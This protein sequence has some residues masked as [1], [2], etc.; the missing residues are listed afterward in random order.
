MSSITAAEKN[1]TMS[2]TDT[3]SDS[4]M[5]TLVA[6]EKRVEERVGKAGR[7]AWRFFHELPGHGALLGGAVG[8][9]GVVFIGFAESW[10]DSDA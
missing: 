3:D 4:G 2:M 8:L 1:N 9:A 5:N 6:I 7:R 10:E